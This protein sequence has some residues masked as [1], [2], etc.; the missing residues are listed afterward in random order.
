MKILVAYLL[1][2]VLP[3]P[4]PCPWFALPSTSAIVRPFGPTGRWSGHWGVDVAAAPGSS[5]RA[6]GSGHISFVGFV[7]ANRTIT[8]DHGG[9]I[10]TSYSYLSATSVRQ[11]QVVVAGTHLGTAMVH[12]GTDSFHLSLRIGGVYVDPMGLGRCSADLSRAL[13]LASPIVLYPRHRVR[14]TRWNLRSSS[15]RAPCARIRFVETVGA[16]R[17]PIRSRGRPVAEGG[18]RSHRCA[19]SAGHDPPGSGR[20]RQIRGERC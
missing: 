16:D 20:A 2:A 8:V 4:I 10:R 19:A 15:P 17:D 3:A 1:L 11:G 13:Y 12:N 14:H 6:I 18:P 9:G 5:V 7:V